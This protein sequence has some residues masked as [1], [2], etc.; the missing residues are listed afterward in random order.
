MDSRKQ[1]VTA[2]LTLTTVHLHKMYAA[3]RTWCVFGRPSV[4][5]QRAVWQVYPLTGQYVC[6]TTRRLVT[7]DCHRSDTLQRHMYIFNLTTM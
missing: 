4:K 3:H 5:R 1:Q 2:L 6:Q 7:E